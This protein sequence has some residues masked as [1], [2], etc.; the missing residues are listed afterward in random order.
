MVAHLTMVIENARS[1][2]DSLLYLCVTLPAIFIAVMG[3][4]VY[5]LNRE[6]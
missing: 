3:V 6:I 1:V 5:V 2:Q 4:M